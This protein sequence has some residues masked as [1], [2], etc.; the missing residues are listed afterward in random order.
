M[1]DYLDDKCKQ[2]FKEVQEYLSILEIPF[3]I[4]PKIVRGLDY[5]TQTAFEV[6]PDN[7]STAQAALGGGG[8][9]D[10]LIE[11]MGGKDTPAVGFAGG[12]SRLLLSLE[13]EK[14]YL[15]TQPS[16]KYY[17]V[18]LGD[19]VIP[20]AI[21]LLSFFRSNNIYI[22]F[23]IEKKSMKSQMKSADRFM[24]E[25]VIILGETEVKQNMVSLKN[26]KTGEQREIL[27]DS[28]AKLTEDPSHP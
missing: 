14:L 15:G 10:G 19:E 20:T 12:F 7:K 28:L 21:K 5:Y 1:L 16:P 17:I 9:Y 18:T 24:A 3:I 23:E 2:H 13:Q 6:I 4:N 25:Y 11:M 26:M 22:E 27:L 8:R